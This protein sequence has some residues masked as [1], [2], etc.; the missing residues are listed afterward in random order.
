MMKRS[1]QGNPVFP[2]MMRNVPMKRGT[3]AFWKEIIES[4]VSVKPRSL[5]KDAGVNIP[6]DLII[7]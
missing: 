1:I 6:L 7:R 5:N 3:T 2:I 4:G